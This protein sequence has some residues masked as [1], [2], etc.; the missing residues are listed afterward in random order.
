ME[1]AIEYLRADLGVILGLWPESELEGNLVPTLGPSAE[2][3]GWVSDFADRVSPAIF[4]QYLQI[5]VGCRPKPLTSSFVSANLNPGWFIDSFGSVERALKNGFGVPL[6]QGDAL[7][8]QAFAGP[9]LR[10]LIEVGTET[11]E[12]HCGLGYATVTCAH[13][14]QE[15]E[16]RGY[17]TYWNCN[18]QNLPSMALARKLGYRSERPYRALTSIVATRA[19]LQKS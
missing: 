19:V 14:I 16:A 12:G 2:Y 4:D 1:R 7:L 9:S 15:C 13:L 11:T 17:R 6:L 18:H 10:G 3:D 5:P 8:G